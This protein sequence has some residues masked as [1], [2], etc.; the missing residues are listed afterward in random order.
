MSKKRDTPRRQTDRKPVFGG[1][2][3]WSLLAAG[4]ASLFAISLIGTSQDLK[5]SYSDLQRLI[6]ATQAGDPDRHVTVSPG[7]DPARSALFGDLHDVVI[8][9]YEVVGK[10]R[11]LTRG[12]RPA[13]P[14]RSELR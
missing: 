11:E 13:A 10:V 2:L 14:A 1:N 9:A 12:P 6:R 4:V 5:I 3:V 8:G 7:D